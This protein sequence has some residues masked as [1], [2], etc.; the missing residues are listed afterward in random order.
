MGETTEIAWTDHTFNPWWGCVRVSPGCERCYAEAFAKRTGHD[1]WGVRAPRRFFGDAYWQ[2]PVKWNADAERDGV[3]RRVF[4]ASMA[5]VF[6][7][8]VGLGIETAMNV[9]QARIGLFRLIEE[10]PALDWQLLT[11]RPENVLRFAPE[12]WRRQFP[13]NV[14]VGATVED[15]KRADERIEHL[16]RVPARRFLSCEPLLERVTLRS[17]GT[18]P[19]KI[20]SLTGRWD[21]PRKDNSTQE[22]RIHWVIVGGESGGRSRPF[23]LAWARSLRDECLVV[24]TP[25]FFKQAGAN[26]H[27]SVRSVVGG[28]RPGD[29]EPKTRLKLLAKK[30]GDIEELPEDLRIRQFPEPVRAC[31]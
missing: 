31:A 2:K 30:G 25:F 27:D 23:D 26:A 6:E 13:A 10:T 1:V 16:L 3:R 12:D 28:W 22:P 11:K 20:D 4:C 15:Q 24:G 19:V 8:P 14:L 21:V 17:I 7:D 9:M 29:P 5:D 18:G